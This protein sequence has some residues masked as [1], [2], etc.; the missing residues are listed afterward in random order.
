[1]VDAAV[2]RE[3]FRAANRIERF[4]SGGGDAPCKAAPLGGGP[5]RYAR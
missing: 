2:N 3:D 5:A 1:M 4:L